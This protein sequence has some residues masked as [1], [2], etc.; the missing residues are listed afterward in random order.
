[1]IIILAATITFGAI[2]ILSVEEGNE[3]ISN[4]EDAIWFSVTT[5]TISGFGDVYPITTYGRIVAAVLSFIGLGIILGFISN[6]GSALVASRLGKA[7]KRLHNETKELIRKKIDNL[8]QLHD[9][10]VADLLSIINSLYMRTKQINTL[11]K[12]LCSM[13][14]NPYLPG[15]LYCNKCGS[16]IM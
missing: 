2:A 3:N 8:E 6:D 10:N 11:P 4:F 12:K 5:L 7:Q 16:K 14:N 13:C 1:L 9:D 15:S